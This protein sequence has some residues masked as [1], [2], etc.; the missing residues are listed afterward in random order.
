MYVYEFMR[1]SHYHRRDGHDRVVGLRSRVS[2]RTTRSREFH[3]PAR[4]EPAH[5]QAVIDSRG[6]RFPVYTSCGFPREAHGEPGSRLDQGHAYTEADVTDKDACIAVLMKQLEEA[7]DE[8]E[9]LRALRPGDATA[10]RWAVCDCG[11]KAPSEIARRS[12]EFRFRGAGSFHATSTCGNCRY[13][14]SAH[15]PDG[16]RPGKA[17][18]ACR[19]F[20]PAG[21]AATDLFYCGHPLDVSTEF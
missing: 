10:G 18:I 6:C 5:A 13:Q 15:L 4:D 9:R 3:A 11:N 2:R 8:I 19:E 7:R 14:W 17:E 16:E 20:T 1:S 12:S 21:A